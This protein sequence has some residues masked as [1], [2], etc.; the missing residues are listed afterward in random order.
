MIVHSFSPER[1]GFD[2]YSR[3][4]EILSLNHR[5][6]ALSSAVLPD[7]RKLYLGWAN[8]DQKYRGM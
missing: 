8:G 4:L 7:G 3:F 1:V 6:G 2:S 5:D